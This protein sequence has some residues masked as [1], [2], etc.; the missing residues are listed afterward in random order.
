MLVAAADT[1]VGT[2]VALFMVVAADTT[3]SLLWDAEG[4]CMVALNVVNSQ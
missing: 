1:A 2:T 4:F 3:A